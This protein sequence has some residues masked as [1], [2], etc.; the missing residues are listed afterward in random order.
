MER[1]LAK[2]AIRERLEAL[3]ASLSESI[4]ATN[5]C[6]LLPTSDELNEHVPR[7]R[8]ADK[9]MF[10]EVEVSLTLWQHVERHVAGQHAAGRGHRDIACRRAGGDRGS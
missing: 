10:P 2:N 3:F 9:P 8:I 7:V 6:L 1:H 4:N 5:A